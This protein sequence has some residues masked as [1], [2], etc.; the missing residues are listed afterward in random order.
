MAPG[1]TQGGSGSTG[2]VADNR[3]SHQR[4]A[5]EVGQ[6]TVAV[7]HPGGTLS[8]FRV[9]C[10]D[11]SS[12]G[13]AFLHRGFL[14]E[15]TE[16]QISLPLMTGGERAVGGKVVRCSHV[17]KNI[18]EVGV[19]FDDQLDPRQ[20]MDVGVE[21][22][23]LNDKPIEMPDLQGRLL[24]VGAEALDF[25]LLQYQLQG[26]A[27]ELVHEASP[28]EAV[29]ETRRTAFDAVICDM[30]LGTSQGGETIAEIRTTG[31]RGPIIAV[32]AERDQASLRKAKQLGASEVILKPYS[33]ATLIGVLSEHLNARGFISSSAEPI[34]STL[35]RDSSLAPLIV[36]FVKAAKAAAAAIREA[37]EQDDVEQ[38]RKL[39]LQLQGN[40]SSYGFKT[41]TDLAGQ[42]VEAIGAAT[43]L[44]QAGNAIEQL[45]AICRRMDVCQVA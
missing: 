41:L 1:S 40:G 9:V 23:E 25:A 10:R 16:C 28:Q 14:Y 21:Y 7:M 42:A 24:F 33:P 5:F 43:S 27:I 26:T 12:G 29:A 36:D 34:L 2:D 31:F 8:K 11:L 35:P 17:K 32:T 30:L 20:F 44:D 37:M 39:C 13:V 6:I 19:C 22:A 15:G 4:L 18:H 3:R 38:V 45:Q